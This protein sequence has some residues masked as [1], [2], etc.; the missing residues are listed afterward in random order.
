MMETPAEISLRV[1][2]DIGERHHGTIIRNI[3]NII[4]IGLNRTTKVVETRPKHNEQLY[5]HLFNTSIPN[6]FKTNLT[7]HHET[8]HL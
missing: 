8:S 2:T 4:T 5:V 7:K 3:R 6:S 1:A